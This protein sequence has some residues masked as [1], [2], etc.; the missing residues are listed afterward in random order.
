MLVS[1]RRHLAPITTAIAAIVLATPAHAQATA[2]TEEGAVITA[3]KHFFDG[4]RTRDTTL[5]RSTVAPGAVLRS[6]G[7]LTGLGDPSTLDAFIERVGKGSGLGNDEQIDNPNV[8]IDGQLASLWAYFTLV[9]GG[10]TRI[11][12]C[13]VDEFLLRKGPDGW[14]VFFIS[15]TH[16]TE[17]CTP[18]AGTSAAAAAA[19]AGDPKDVASQSAILAALYDVISGPAGKKRDWD[20]FRSLF[21]PGARLIPTGVG[22]D[23]KARI[24]TM[25][26]DEYATATGSR[27]EQSGFFE[28]EISRTAE[29]YGNVTQAFSTY[30]SRHAAVDEKPF[31]RGINSIQLFNDGTR[32]WVVTIYWDSERPGNEIPARFLKKP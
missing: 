24:R 25:S 22:P 10:E 28:K 3:V 20:R 4:M 17:G 9:R 1:A 23:G 16:R 7:G 18:I 14:K 8:L 27:L 26:P 5:M 29:T 31:A 30:E 21:V 13:G 2:Q 6:A 15:D 32:W 11:N 12:H 19:A